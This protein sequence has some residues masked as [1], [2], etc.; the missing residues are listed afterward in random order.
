VSN[1]AAA[2]AKTQLHVALTQL[3]EAARLARAAGLHRP[4]DTTEVLATLQPTPQPT[5]SVDQAAG[6]NDQVVPS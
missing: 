2:N 3:D 4:A 5:P 6:D 1:R